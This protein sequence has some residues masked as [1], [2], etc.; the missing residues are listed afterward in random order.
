MPDFLLNNFLTSSHF[1]FIFGKLPI[2]LCVIR[3][4]LKNL[5]ES[6]RV[7]GSKNRIFVVAYIASK[8]RVKYVADSRLSVSQNFIGGNRS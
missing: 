7:T 6:S 2:L 4:I 1:I 5:R 8:Y 3:K